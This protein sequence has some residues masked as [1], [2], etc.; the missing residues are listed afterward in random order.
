[1]LNR[2]GEPL[3]VCPQMTKTVLSIQDAPAPPPKPITRAEKETIFVNALVRNT[4]FAP[5][6]PDRVTTARAIV[7]TG[8]D[9][10]EKAG[11]L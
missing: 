10:L 4:K 9:A 7:K 8:F 5:L 3:F 2:M 1:M 6:D 11:A